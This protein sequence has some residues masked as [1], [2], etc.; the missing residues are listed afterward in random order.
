MSPIVMTAPK[1]VLLVE[2]NHDD[3]FFFARALKRAAPDWE[4]FA[5]E[6]SGAALRYLEAGSHDKKCL[7]AAIF[8]DLHLPG[9]DPLDLF[10]RI[11]SMPAMS[12]VLRFALTGSVDDAIKLRAVQ[13]GAQD[14]FAKPLNAS[15]LGQALAC[16]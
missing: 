16:A 10:A 9:S 11:R 12:A 2:D 7:P 8:I 15:E 1:T 13:A 14:V 5:V 3:T 4:L 6:D